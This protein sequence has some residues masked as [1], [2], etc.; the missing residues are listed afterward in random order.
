[1]RAATTAD[2]AVIGVA[3]SSNDG[4]D[5]HRSGGGSTAHLITCQLH[6]A[7]GGAGSGGVTVGVGPVAANPVDGAT[8][9]KTCQRDGAA[10]GNDEFV[11]F[12]TPP[13][14]DPAVVAA[15]LAQQALAE[16]TLPQ[17]A[18]TSNPPN[19]VDV[20]NV[21]VW[22]WTNNWATLTATATA[23]GVSATVTAAPT[24]IAWNMGDGHT[25]VCAGP[26]T[27]YN[28]AV[29][30]DA[31][32]TDCSYTYWQKAGDVTVTAT[33]TWH[34]TYTA[35]NGEAGDLG[36]ATRTATMPQHIHSLVTSIVQLPGDS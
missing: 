9:V 6:E 14:P 16:I 12:Q 2:G 19:G 15:D 32:H 3:N 1:M 8:Y 21:P 27:A 29:A 24:Q 18:I 10:V 33:E 28:A 36:T 7:S 13:P 30:D 20:I 4:N 35:T 26:G 31:Q 22:L 17:P 23:A 11:V 34:I 5:S 25:V